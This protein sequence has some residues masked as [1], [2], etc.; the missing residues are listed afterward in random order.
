MASAPGKAD[1]FECLTGAIA[2]AKS[3]A[4]VDA[5][6]ADAALEAL[7][8]FRSEFSAL[9]ASMQGLGAAPID[10]D[11]IDR[12]AA[13]YGDLCRA[14]VP[15]ACTELTR[16]AVIVPVCEFGLVGL[17]D[18]QAAIL[19]AWHPIRLYERR[20]KLGRMAEIASEIRRER[21]LM[22]GHASEAKRLR[23]IADEHRL[24]EA[25]VVGQEPYHVVDSL[26]GYGL[27]VSERHEGTNRTSLDGSAELASTTF[28]GVVDDY[29]ELNPHEEANL[30]TAIYGA[31]STHLPRLLTDG[32]EGRM[33][34]NRDLRCELFITH[35]REQELR[36]I[37]AVQNAIL[38]ERGTAGDGG[39]L[40]RLRVGV[41]PN[42]GRSGRAS[43]RAD[44]DVVL[45]HDAYQNISR[46]DWNLEKGSAGE[47]PVASDLD[48]WIA[49]RV[50]EFEEGPGD[51]RRLA[52]SLGVSRPP[53]LV[54]HFLD[55]CYL[56]RRN[57]THIPDG[58][59]ASPVRTARWRMDDTSLGQIGH[60]VKSAHDLGEW[61]V[62][63]DRMSTR[64]MLQSFG[65]EVI[66][67]IP[68]KASDHRILVSASKPSEA[69]RRRITQRFQLFHGL[70][71]LDQADAQAGAA[72]A[73]VV[74]VAGQKLLGAN[75]SANAANEIIGLAA[76]ARIVE[77]ELLGAGHAGKPI[78]ISLDEAKAAFEMTGKVADAVALTVDLDGSRPMLS[79]VIVE[80]KCV[81]TAGLTEQAKASR[82]QTVSSVRDMTEHL[83]Q[84][85]DAADKRCRCCDVLHLMASKPEFRAALPD[86][87]QRR[88]FVEAM[89]RGEVDVEVRGLS[90]VVAHDA[91]DDQIMKR[92]LDF[93]E[94]ATA[95]SLQIVLSRREL[96]EL[97]TDG[98]SP[99]DLSGYLSWTE[100]VSD[101]DAGIEATVSEPPAQ[102]DAARLT[103][104]EPEAPMG[105]AAELYQESTSE[106]ADGE[107]I[108]CDGDLKPLSA[109]PA[110]VAEFIA[111]AA[112]RPQAREDAEAV[113]AEAD[114][115]ADAIQDALL[116]YGMEARFHDD[117]S[118]I[119]PNGTLFRFKGHKTLTERS[120]RAR[121][122]EMHTTHGIDVVYLRPGKGWLGL[123]VSAEKRR[124]VHL[125]NLWMEANW[126]ET[127]P[128]ANT[129]ILLGGREDDGRPLWLN[130]GS[131]HDGQPEHAPHTLIAGETGSGKG[132]LLQSILLQLAATND[133]RNLRIELIDPKQ[134]ADFFWLEPVPHLDGE[135]VT[136]PEDSVQTL[137]ELVIEM[138][139]RYDLIVGAKTRNIDEYNRRASEADR[140]PRIVV[141]HDEMASWMQGDEDYRKAVEAA[142]TDLASKSRAAGIHMILVTQRASQEAIPPS[143]REN[144]GNRLCLKV[145]SDKGSRLALGV[146]GAEDLLGKG[147]LAA[148]LPGDAPSGSDF[149]IAQVP[150]ISSDDLLAMGELI[151]RSWREG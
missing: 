53:R 91:S 5:A 25:L 106:D 50:P 40:S 73:T 78:W 32:I 124:T 35:D 9:V 125:A 107:P 46:I 61:V 114:R 142:L 137:K 105:P 98:T 24:P 115:M 54:G 127:A 72:I 129:S 116:Q 31:E 63:I 140:L 93:S 64:A 45:L 12:T 2:K 81:E 74:R 6:E 7:G 27:A 128:V 71:L 47:M 100:A 43:S 65:I 80:A 90:V 77:G 135:I 130:L 117:P 51:N 109:F 133:P 92:D 38:K 37:Y 86:P 49:P 21:G 14:V 69:L 33:K 131:E 121:L 103:A 1:F 89:L 132:N 94:D 99:F 56:A 55:L 44:I 39:F 139:R 88:R 134:G 41:L 141:A 111:S 52:M 28:L 79:M 62:S 110:P 4:S 57:H 104:P 10:L 23:I 113:A 144:M 123:F 118:T 138:N 15:F 122:S 30:S 84:N 119:T 8:T 85:G 18:Q 58:Q 151:G 148:G 16:D 20:V 97:L 102:P 59:H 70:R 147:H 48:D 149:H 22:D 66:R 101:A 3:G 13:S 146:G 26:M 150:F 87:K 68:A 112:R 126:P 29:L 60:V 75:R 96:S 143:V 82:E 19:P 42:R 136:T 108:P 120:V 145:A 76:A 95:P 83:V 11:L 34:S 17:Q 36:E 67:D